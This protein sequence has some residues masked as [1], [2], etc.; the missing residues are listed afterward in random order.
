MH[1]CYCKTHRFNKY[2]SLNHH[3]INTFSRKHSNKT[4]T[5]VGFYL[6]EFVLMQDQK[7]QAYL[8]G[9]IGVSGK[10]KWDVLDGVIRRLFKVNHAK[11]LDVNFLMCFI[12]DTS[13]SFIA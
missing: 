7:P 6:V 9:S 1:I 11:Y 10:T 13:L 4:N 3:Y 12:L 8:I 5:Q 2:I